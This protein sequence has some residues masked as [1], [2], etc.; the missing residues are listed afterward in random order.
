MASLL[1]LPEKGVCLKGNIPANNGMACAAGTCLT[2]SAAVTSGA[3]P[4]SGDHSRLYLHLGC[5]PVDCQE[6]S[7]EDL[8]DFDQPWR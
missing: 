8:V 7:P 5:Q 3:G 2:S 6:H 4:G 1:G